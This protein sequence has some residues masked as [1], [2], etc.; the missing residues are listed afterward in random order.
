M[1]QSSLLL[2]RCPLRHPCACFGMDWSPSSFGAGDLV[3]ARRQLW[4]VMQ[5]VQD[6]MAPLRLRAGAAP[7]AAVTLVRDEP[8][9]LLARAAYG[10]WLFPAALERDKGARHLEELICGEHP[11]GG[12][13]VRRAAAARLKELQR[14]EAA[15]LRTVGGTG[16]ANEADDETPCCQD[17][18]CRSDPYE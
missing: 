18:P 14:E 1:G 6:A 5:G 17:A 12:P 3:Y 4:Y 2:S 8:V 16:P 11:D 15:A 10:P 7:F 9:R 13:A